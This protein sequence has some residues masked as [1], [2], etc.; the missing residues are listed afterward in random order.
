MTVWANPIGADRPAQIGRQPVH[1]DQAAP[2][3]QSGEIGPRALEQLAADRRMD[4]VRANQ[5]VASDGC[6]RGE[7]CR[8]P[9][10]LVTV[11]GHPRPGADRVGF[12]GRDGLPQHP[13]QISAMDE[14]IRR[15]K[16]LPGVGAEIK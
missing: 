4:P 10:A 13:V 1:V 6:S 16:P 8:D 3:D 7:L 11:T 12:Q 5:N 15:A 14:P 2:G 9:I